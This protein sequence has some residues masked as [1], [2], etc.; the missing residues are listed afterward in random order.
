V[1]L[2]KSAGDRKAAVRRREPQEAAEVDSQRAGFSSSSRVFAR[3]PGSRRTD[4]DARKPANRYSGNTKEHVVHK[5]RVFA[6]R[7]KRAEKRRENSYCRHGAVIRMF[8]ASTLSTA[9]QR[10][11]TQ[12]SS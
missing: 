8:C 2:L 4:S 9:V 1:W 12:S 3:L 10:L 5:E 7:E 6:A 11:A